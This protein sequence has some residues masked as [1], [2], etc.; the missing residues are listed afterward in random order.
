MEN[1]KLYVEGWEGYSTAYFYYYPESSEKPILS[2]TIPERFAID[3]MEYHQ[4]ERKIRRTALS[5]QKAFESDGQE[6]WT[7]LTFI[8]NRDGTFH[9]DYGY[10]DL[11]E[12]DPGEQR[13][14]WKAKYGIE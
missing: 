2:Y 10:E 9:V 4:Q 7:N 12:A 3:K 1:V 14:A 13:E 11:T 6:P 5:I 8:L